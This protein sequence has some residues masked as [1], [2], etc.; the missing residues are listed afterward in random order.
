MTLQCPHCGEAATL[1]RR[2]VL[3]HFVI[4]PSCDKHFK[5]ERTAPNESEAVWGV[6]GEE[7]REAEDAR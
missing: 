3:G 2:D 6:D 7:H 5:W 4:C 1:N